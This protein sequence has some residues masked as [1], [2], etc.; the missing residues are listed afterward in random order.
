MPAIDLSQY[1]KKKAP[2][3]GKPGGEGGILAFLN[4]DISFGARS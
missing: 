3:P 4:R 2:K 1:E